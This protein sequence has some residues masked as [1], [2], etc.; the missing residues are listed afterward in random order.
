MQ[1][2]ASVY[3]FTSAQMFLLRQRHSYPPPP[4][5][6]WQTASERGGSVQLNGPI[7]TESQWITLM[8]VDGLLLFATI[9]IEPNDVVLHLGPTTQHPI[10]D[11]CHVSMHKSLCVPMSVLQGQHLGMKR[12][13]EKI[14]RKERSTLKCQ[15]K[16][17]IEA[18]FNYY[19]LGLQ[20]LKKEKHWSIDV[21]SQ[22]PEMHFNETKPKT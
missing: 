12:H 13:V 3:W 6:V 10:S 5:G 11:A 15:W 16:Q 19:K 20:L 21:H 14:K 2:C 22:F 18:H 8:P 17:V 9:H 4:A 7:S 1:E